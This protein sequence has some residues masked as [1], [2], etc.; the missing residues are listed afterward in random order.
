M[1][2]FT[3]MV[4]QFQ[5]IALNKQK[6]QNH[7]TILTDEW[8]NFSCTAVYQPWTSTL[9]FPTRNQVVSLIHVHIAIVT[10]K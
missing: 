6:G 10:T 7:S 2:K 3:N 5:N 9:C 1:S 8:P 4:M